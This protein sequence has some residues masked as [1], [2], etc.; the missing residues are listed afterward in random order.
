LW[1]EG[2]ILGYNAIN[3]DKYVVFLKYSSNG[4]PLLS[5]ITFLNKLLKHKDFLNL[6]ILE[7]NSNYLVLTE[8]GFFSSV[9]CKQFGYGGRIFAKIYTGV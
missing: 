5:K 4:N 9:N 7:K 1:R 8:K 6:S 2:Y 3:F